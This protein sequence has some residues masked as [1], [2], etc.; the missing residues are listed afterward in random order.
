VSVAIIG[1]GVVGRAQAKLFGDV[2]TYDIAR[3]EPYPREA[4]AACDFAVIAVGTPPLPDGSADLSAVL[5][6]VTALPS[7]LPVLIRSTVPPGTT[8]R[9]QA[10]YPSRLVGHAPEFLTERDGGPWPESADVPFLVLGG[11]PEARR[12]FRQHLQRVFTGDIHETTA[13]EAELVKYTANLHWATRV[14]FVNEMARVCAAFGT[15]WE[16]VRAGWQCDERVSPA[17]TRMA[18]FPPGFGGACW[19]KDLAALIAASTGAG[20]DPE[21]LRAVAAANDRFRGQA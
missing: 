1:M 13:T 2:V 11:S 6:A 18:G 4:I 16:D 5:R 3:E 9:L 15:D 17:Y 20:H 8:D 19:P 10:A 7:G 14:T 12:F 21:F